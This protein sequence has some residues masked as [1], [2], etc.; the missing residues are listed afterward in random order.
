M[1]ATPPRATDRAA[2]ALGALGE[3][4]RER[5]KQLKLS[6]TAAAEAADMSR[7]TWHRLE[8]GEPSVTIGAYLNALAVLG[9]ELLVFDPTAA[10]PAADPAVD[11]PERIRLDDYPQ[12]RALA[13]QTGAATEVTP[14]EA[15]S[16][17]ER[18]WRHVDHGAMTPDE[19]DLIRRLTAV[20]GGGRLLV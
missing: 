6:A 12:L 16:L 17:Y 15:L 20:L 1:P 13:W 10:G 11:L 3:R 7:V 5:R 14:F 8:R 19:R 2:R 9:L 4:I 18:N